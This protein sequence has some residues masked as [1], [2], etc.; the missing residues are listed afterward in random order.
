[1]AI[2]A[3]RKSVF[4]AAR[5]IAIFW[6]GFMLLAPGLAWSQVDE[7]VVTV[8]KKSE[9]LQDVP[10]SV[11][12]FDAN[13]IQ[14][15]GIRNVTDV[16][17][18]TSSIQ[19]DES[20][21]QSDTRIAVR[22]LSPTRGRQNVALLVD[23][24]DVSSESITSSGGSLLVNTR[25]IDIERI[26]VVLGPQMA[27]YGRSA[28][29][30]ALQYI[31]RDP[32]DKFETELKADINDNSGYEL[33]G[34]VSGPILGDKLGY[35]FNAT[36]WE[37]EGFY[38]N[39]ITGAPIGGNEGWGVAFTLKSNIGD[40]FSLK[41][42]TEYTDDSSQP[43]AQAFLPF[44]AELDVPAGAVAAGIAECNSALVDA[45]SDWDDP[46]N[47]NQGV[48]GNN[49]AWLARGL[50]ILDPAY[51]AT[52]D[53]ATLDPDLESFEIP[54]GGGA[55]CEE[56]APGRVG[57]IPDAGDLAITLAPNPSTPGQD[58]AGAER[59][60]LRFSLVADWTSDNY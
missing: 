57:E 20:F 27:L 4:I 39:S 54:A 47:P 44:N 22:G 21:A 15:Q 13:T 10:L 32:A 52:L 35:R 60:L 49:E 24:I 41:F 28:F 38:D 58:Y 9:N 37:Q 26:E 53:P 11:K 23:G 42:R 51:V 45:L 2:N 25:L 7:V 31:T 48:E 34:S 59:E 6:L 55:Y 14:T 40:N 50:R 3:H 36:W 56:R 29:N 1:M 8:R 12:A 43:S 19:F 17:K 18:Y 5:T 30:G 46:S 16:A 33:I